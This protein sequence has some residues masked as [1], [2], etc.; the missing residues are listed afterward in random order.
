MGDW[1]RELALLRVDEEETLSSVTDN[2]SKYVPTRTSDVS[3][4]FSL[5]PL[6]HD[7]IINHTTHIST[8]G[9]E[10]PRASPIDA[11]ANFQVFRRDDV[12]LVLFPQM[13]PPLLLYLLRI[14]PYTQ[15]KVKASWKCQSKRLREHNPCFCCG[16][17]A[18]ALVQLRCP[19]MVLSECLPS[20]T[21]AAEAAHQEWYH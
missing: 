1:T 20:L 5:E 14:A 7:P 19:S 21:T 15:R 9:G 16:L 11:L 10:K 17:T 3:A 4:D 13:P 12:C 2:R 8:D 18:P 6:C